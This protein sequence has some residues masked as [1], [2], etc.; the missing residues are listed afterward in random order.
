M[1]SLVCICGMC[2]GCVCV[3]VRVVCFLIAEN[4]TYEELSYLTISLIQDK[5]K[6]LLKANKRD[7]LEAQTEVIKVS[8]L[9]HIYLNIEKSHRRSI[10]IL[11]FY[12]TINYITCLE[13]TK[14][15]GVAGTDY[16]C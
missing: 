15:E 7:S 1:Y 4:F 13:G 8:S 5:A 16:N 9:H 10:R 11:P 12:F 3:C 14:Q 6:T 2:V